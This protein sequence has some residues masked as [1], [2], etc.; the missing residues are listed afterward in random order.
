MITI[1]GDKNIKA[2]LIIFLLK[3]IYLQIKWSIFY[4]KVFFVT[5]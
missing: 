3:Y 4:V 1:N 2:I 5:F